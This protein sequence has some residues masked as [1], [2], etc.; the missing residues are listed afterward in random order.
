M[1]HPQTT[2]NCA[3]RLLSLET[4]QVMGILNITPDSFYSGSRVMEE[5]DIVKLA[6]KMLEEGAAILDVGGMSTRPGA[7]PPTPQE[8]LHRV[9]PAIEAIIRHFP[10]AIVSI[11][12]VRASVAE[13]AIDA[14]A[15]IINDIAAGKMDAQMYPTVARLKVPYILMHM[16]GIPETMH[17]NPHYDDIALEILDFFIAETGKLRELGVLDIVLDP[18]FGFG[19]TINHN[20]ELLR[21]MHVF[22]ILDLPILAGL[23]RKSMIYKTLGIQPEEALNGASALHIIALQQGARLLRVHDVKAAVEVVRLW[24]RVYPSGNSTDEL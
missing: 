4:P 7:I 2:L 11:D 22:R 5:A 19:K 17:Q 6:G 21:K 18:G 15:A 24:Q 10:E 13:A 1:Y 16:Q 20:F 9:I 12:T 8:E 3:G 14:G 23:S